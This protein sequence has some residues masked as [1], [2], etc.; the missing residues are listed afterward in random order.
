MPDPALTNHQFKIKGN[1]LWTLTQEFYDE[2]KE[3][4]P[5]HDVEG[6]MRAAKL[7]CKTV[8]VSKRKTAKGMRRFLMGWVGRAEATGHVTVDPERT[9]LEINYDRVVKSHID[10]F[11]N[12]I[13]ERTVAELKANKMFMAASRYPEFAKWALEQRPDLKQSTPVNKFISHFRDVKTYK[14]KNPE[15][16]ENLS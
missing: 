16:F 9:P 12:I 10:M 8:L 2:L 15:K 3:A 4:Y 14:E 11:S 7:W 6:E 13:H 1:K 5:L